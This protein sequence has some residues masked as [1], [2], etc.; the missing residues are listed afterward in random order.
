LSRRKIH[1]IYIES[2]GGHRAAAKALEAVICEQQRPWEVRL[3]NIQDLLNSIDV[4][5]KLTG[6]QVQEVYNIMLRRGWTLGTAQLIPL[7]HGVIRM[8]HDAQVRVL[9]RHWSTD[10]PDMVVSLIPHYNRAFKQALARVCPAAPLVT[11]LTDI[12][13]YPPH[14]WIERQD[15]YVICGSSRAV[16]QARSLGYPDG[17]ILRTSGMILH[18]KFYQPLQL[19]RAAER[20]RLGLCPDLPTALVSFGAEG[21]MEA[22]KVASAFRNCRYGVQLII[23][24]GRHE[25]ASAKLLSIRHGVPVFVQ[26]FTS[27]VPY[28]MSLADLFIGKPGPGTISEALAMKLPVIVERN[29]WTLAHERYNAAWIMEQHAGP[30]VDNFSQVAE[31]VAELLSP[32][33]YQLCR[34]SAAAVQNRSVYEIPSLLET[35]LSDRSPRPS[36]APA[37]VVARQ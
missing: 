18:P 20:R 26:G 25:Q 16:T 23:L 28:Y 2:G 1:F 24:C 12:A 21:S 9:E 33:R 22:V 17:R 11:I 10:P 14:F 5:R 8:F 30:V 34:A 37:G 3:S 15:Q 29:H 7:M 6:I 35:I 4:I 13:D 31:A 19:D 32:E 27:D 36:T